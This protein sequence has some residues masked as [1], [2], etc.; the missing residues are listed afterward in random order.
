M[1]MNFEYLAT[2]ADIKNTPQGHHKH[3][4]F[5]QLNPSSKV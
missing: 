2:K 4:G 5:R 1:E 3:N